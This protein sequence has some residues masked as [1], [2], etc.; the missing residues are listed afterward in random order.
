[1]LRA[2][3]DALNDIYN[4][5]RL[6]AWT[7]PYL[8]AVEKLQELE[9][10]DNAKR[11]ILAELRREQDMSPTRAEAIEVHK[12]E[13]LMRQEEIEDRIIQKAVAYLLGVSAAAD[14]GT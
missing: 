7:E 1:M 3:T 11:T 9:N 6:P 10:S 5:Q 12:E 13:Y 8:K 4:G 2:A 14:F